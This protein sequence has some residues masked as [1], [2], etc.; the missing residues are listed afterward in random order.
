VLADE[1]QIDRWTAFHLA[2]ARLR[3][4]LTEAHRRLPRDGG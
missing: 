4:V 2:H 3:L 1:E